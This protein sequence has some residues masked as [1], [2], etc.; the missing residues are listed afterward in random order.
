MAAARQN[1]CRS[2]HGEKVRHCSSNWRWGEKSAKAGRIRERRKIKMICLGGCG[3]A[4]FIRGVER[5]QNGGQCTVF[6]PGEEFRKRAPAEICSSKEIFFQ[7][8][9]KVFWIISRFCLL[10]GL[11]LRPRPLP[12]AVS[13]SVTGNRV[14]QAYILARPLILRLLP[15]ASSLAAGRRRTFLRGMRLRGRGCLGGGG[16]GGVARPSNRR[17]RQWAFGRGLCWKG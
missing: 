6:A 4:A 12:P 5:E 13:P 1:C 7:K 11:G 16:G 10:C 14:L 3:V 15:E 8:F 9:L 2:R 17:R